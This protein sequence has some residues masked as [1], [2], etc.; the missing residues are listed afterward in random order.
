MPAAY[1]TAVNLQSRKVNSVVIKF[2][3]WLDVSGSL[4]IT[5]NKYHCV[6]NLNLLLR[7]SRNS[8]TFEHIT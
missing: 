2:F 1:G 5:N 4:R 8:L 3:D 7:R 6:F